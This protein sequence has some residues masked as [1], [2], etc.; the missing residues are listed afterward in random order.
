MGVISDTANTVWRDFEKV[1]N[2]S[3]GG[4][5]PIK[6]E[7]RNLFSIVDNVDPID[8]IATA[9]SQPLSLEDVS[10]KT[11]TL[12]D[13]GASDGVAAHTAFN[14]AMAAGVTRLHIHKTYTWTGQAIC[15][16]DGCTL[17]FT[18]FQNKGFNG[19]LFVNSVLRTKWMGLRLRCL[20]FSGLG[21]RADTWD[22][23]VLAYCE[24]SDFPEDGH[25]F[26]VINPNVSARGLFLG[27]YF[28]SVN[29]SASTGAPDGDNA[30]GIK[31]YGND[32][33]SD[34]G[35]SSSFIAVSGR[36]DLG[37]TLEARIVGTQATWPLTW[38][39]TV[40]AKISSSRMTSQRSDNT[41][42]LKGQQHCIVG[43]SSGAN[44]IVQASE[45]QFSGNSFGGSVVLD[46]A[47]I[48]CSLMSNRILG[49]I[50]LT[51]NYSGFGGGSYY[52]PSNTTT[53]I[54][55]A[56]YASEIVGK[57]TQTTNRTWTLG[58]GGAVNGMRRRIMHAAIGGFTLTIKNSIGTTL[59]T[60]SN[61]Q[62]KD[63]EL[64]AGEWVAV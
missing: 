38:A 44:L 37:G 9:A 58:L 23:C 51:A 45:C 63:F 4:H 18:K 8:P 2:P 52:G 1:G 60:L 30:C 29:G 47:G 24:C 64:T 56:F 12:D 16:V 26:E 27:G 31:L 39:T 17:W 15:N 33:L 55:P 11:Y 41:I 46:A 62:L 61:G 28:A 32:S 19:D 10:A 48:N 59:V 3:S 25:F 22:R 53:T 40:Q 7:I 42:T 57:L 50:T 34:S 6:S 43:I 13:F 20:G 21:I 5:K 49:G 54:N 36:I 14:A 35:S